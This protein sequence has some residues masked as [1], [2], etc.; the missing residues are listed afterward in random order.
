M[1]FLWRRLTGWAI[2]HWQLPER[3]RVLNGQCMVA[4][5]AWVEK[6]RRVTALAAQRDALEHRVDGLL[7][8]AV[9]A[10]VEIAEL[11]L[12][13]AVAEDEFG[14]AVPGLAPAEIE[15]LAILAEE[16][17]E[18][19]QAVG[20]VLRHGWDS[21][22]PYGGKPNLQALERELGNVRA[23]VN[24]MLDAGDVRLAELQAWQRRKREQ[25]EKWTHHQ[26]CSMPREAQI[27]MM[28]GIELERLKQGRLEE[29]R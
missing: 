25:M 8:K 28:R 4:T 5:A 26:E 9:R 29:S 19:V 1:K 13:V 12:R 7:A 17:G 14:P 6:C 27:R 11:Q 24:L 2:W 16:C 10:N 20:K 18:V 3:Y 15:R 23:I 22:S 21:Q